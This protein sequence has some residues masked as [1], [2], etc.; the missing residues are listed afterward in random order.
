MKTAARPA[1][2]RAFRDDLAH[3]DA[4][5]VDRAAELHAVLSV[6]AS[7]N[8][9]FGADHTFLAGDLDDLARE[10]VRLDVHVGAVAKAF[11]EA[12]AAVTLLGVTYAQ[13]DH[14]EAVL[15]RLTAQAGPADLREL[16]VPLTERAWSELVWGALV[17]PPGLLGTY[18]GGGAVIGPDGRLYPLVVP[19]LE[20]DGRVAHATRAADIASDPGTL[21][22]SDAGWVTL[23]TRS[24]VARIADAP[25]GWEKASAFAGM[26][27]GLDAAIV[28]FASPEELA[29]LDVDA[30]GW[31][32]LRRQPS[33]AGSLPPVPGYLE[34]DDDLPQVGMGT[35]PDGTGVA[36]VPAPRPDTGAKAHAG[37][38]APARAS[39]A[40][41]AARPVAPSSA[42][43][44]RP[45]G[46]GA[47]GAL[48]FVGGVARGADAVEALDRAGMAA[49]QVVYETHA[50]GRRR[51]AQLRL[52]QIERGQH[53]SPAKITPTLGYV[54][55]DRFDQ[56]PLRYH[57]PQAPTIGQADVGVPAIVREQPTVRP[58]PPHGDGR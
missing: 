30:A 27:T 13:H 10:L 1:G 19:E 7:T 48:E 6:Y 20:I 22:G 56:T 57:L 45:P 42:R 46:A 8:A 51:R 21:G 24:G 35:A 15:S 11:E 4:A 28:V 2:L 26:A 58:I 12:D 3:R 31:P 47:S 32:S 40:Q 55:G 38:K 34:V 36:G 50:D 43:P 33:P 37:R 53:D 54:D 44:R 16:L 25:A 23:A 41:R 14:V 5:L 18:G 9:D 29:A 17:C 52:F 49:Y 39:A